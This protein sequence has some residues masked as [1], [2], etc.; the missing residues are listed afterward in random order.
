MEHG[1]RESAQRRSVSGAHV[2]AVAA[3]PGGLLQSGS[4]SAHGGSCALRG[5]TGRLCRM[6]RTPPARS[7][8]PLAWERAGKAEEAPP[9]QSDAAQASAAVTDVRKPGKHWLRQRAPGVSGQGKGPEFFTAEPWLQTAD[10][11][12]GPRP[13][14]SSVRQVFSMDDCP[15]SPKRVRLPSKP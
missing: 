5:R 11:S 3:A 10:P 9:P 14:A 7:R 13:K 2:R 1:F 6:P 12:Y 8:S 15:A 4:D